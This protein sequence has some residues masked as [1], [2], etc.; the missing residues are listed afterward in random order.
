MISY[1]D[2][3]TLI[4]LLIDEP[5][6]DRAAQLWDSADR[7]V[8]VGLIELEARAALAAA[9]RAKRLT[10]AEH[11]RAKT[12]LTA[13]LDQVDII[14]VTAQLITAACDLAES[15]GLRGY[16][17]V[18]LAAAVVVGVDAFTSADADLCAAAARHG[19]SVANPIR[20]G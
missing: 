9:E 17:A 15:E 18:H 10:G 7:L 11:R 8:S 14:E 4:K 19:L 12:S 20:E 3:S 16:D 13:H 1:L 5:G 2:T 6:S